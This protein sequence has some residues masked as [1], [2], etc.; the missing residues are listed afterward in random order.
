MPRSLAPLAAR[1]RRVRDL[2]AK[3]ETQRNGRP[4]TRAEIAQG[5]VGDVGDL[6][7]LLM[8]RDGVRPAAQLDARLR[9]EFGDC[10]WCLFVLA[11]AYD[12]NLEEAFHHTMDY[13]EG[14]LVTRTGTK[15]K[16]QKR[17]RRAK[18]K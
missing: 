7:K 9:H 17:S 2:Y 8:A 6:M 14:Q 18:V 15:K 3:L 10:L 11:D 13:L 16:V 5:F 4:W 1:A 12:V